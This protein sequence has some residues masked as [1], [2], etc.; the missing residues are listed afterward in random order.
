MER[1]G[2][3]GGETTRVLADWLPDRRRKKNETSDLA[4]PVLDTD[5]YDYRAETVNLEE[6]GIAGRRLESR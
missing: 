2:R 3:V 5:F 1:V 6:K 4:M